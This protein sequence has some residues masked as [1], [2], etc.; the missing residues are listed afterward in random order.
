MLARVLPRLLSLAWAPCG[1][2]A[3]PPPHATTTNTP[4]H[5][6]HT[7]TTPPPPQAWLDQLDDQL[8]PL[9]NFILPSGGRPAAHLHMA[10]AVCRRAE[11]SVVPLVREGA[12]DAQ[13]SG[14]QRW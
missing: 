1:C 3:T 5:H 6:H 11:R 14:Q 4:A 7:T 9:K 13:V 10:R 8:P 2:A 12:V